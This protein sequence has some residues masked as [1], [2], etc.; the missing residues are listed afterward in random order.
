MSAYT[1]LLYQIVFG[2][3]NR[4]RVLTKNNRAILF[5]YIAGIIQNKNCHLYIIN[6]VEDHV[7]IVTH[8]HQSIALASFV[9]DVKV[10]SSIFIK[11]QK[12]FDNFSSWQVGYGA[13]TYSIKE[14]NRVVAYVANQEKHHQE[15]TFLEEYIKLL[16]QNGVEYDEQYLL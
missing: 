3:K 12:L 10:A 16:K 9:K 11:E 5:N 15:K 7:H 4:E 13:F 2:T 8:I 6:G 1:Q 14:L